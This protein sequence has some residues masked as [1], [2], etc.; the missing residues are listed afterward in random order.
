MAGGGVVVGAAGCVAGSAPGVQEPVGAARP[1]QGADLAAAGRSWGVR[2][3]GPVDTDH[4]PALGRYRCAEGGAGPVPS[5]AAAGCN[6][7]LGS[8]HLG[9]LGP[10]AC[11]GRGTAPGCW[12][13]RPNRPG[14]CRFGG[15][16]LGV[17]VHGRTVL[18]AGAVESGTQP[19]VPAASA[20]G[21]ANNETRTG[22]GPPGRPSPAWRPAKPTPARTG[23]NKPPPTWCAASGT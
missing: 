14:R 21:P 12:G 18:Y 17:A 3:P 7:A 20:G 11:L 13:H 2:D 15:G 9:R 19:T 4:Q 5:V 23:S 16:G 6:S 10:P 8:G 22:S 1:F